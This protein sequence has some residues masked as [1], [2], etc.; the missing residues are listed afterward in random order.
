M[1]SIRAFTAIPLPT[2]ILDGIER[3]QRKLER[4]VPYRSVRWVRPAAIHLTLKFFGDIS[5]SKVPGVE[6]ALQTVALHAPGCCCTV[7]GLGCFPTPQRP[8]VIWVGIT[9]TSGR[10][11]ALQDAIEEAVT[12]LGFERE[13]RG[14]TP[15]LTLGRVTRRATR[16]DAAELGS[17]IRQTDVGELGE[18]T[19]DRICLIKSTLKPTGAEYSVLRTF[20]LRKPGDIQG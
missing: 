12:P 1:Q 2:S 14:F 3:I 18:V 20:E 5:T 11:A 19:V 15:H 9:E 16:E 13:R 10:L 6:E 17:L 7:S 4:D 8:R